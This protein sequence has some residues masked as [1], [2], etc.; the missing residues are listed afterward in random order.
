MAINKLKNGK[1]T[2]HD[3]ILA[4]FITEG[5]IELK[6]VIYEFFKYM[7]GTGHITR[8]K[9]GIMFP[10]HKKVDVMCDNYIAVIFL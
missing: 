9:Y 4:K 2:G 8:W 6:K 1:E 10:T 7:G 5:G 3:Q